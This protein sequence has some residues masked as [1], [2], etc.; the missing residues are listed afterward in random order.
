M[1]MLRNTSRKQHQRMGVVRGPPQAEP[2]VFGGQNNDDVHV[3][4]E[5]LCVL[6]MR[7]L[8]GVSDQ[9]D[10]GS[11]PRPIRPGHTGPAHRPGFTAGASFVVWT[12]YPAEPRPR[13]SAA[14]LRPHT[15]M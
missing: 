15:S 2:D 3:S 8:G 14:G 13:D 11:G 5:Y 7:S 1:E 12:Q 6:Q 9:R 4:A 10:G